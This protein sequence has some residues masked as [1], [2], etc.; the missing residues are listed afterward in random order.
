M[1]GDVSVSLRAK[2]QSLTLGVQTSAEAEYRGLAVADASCE[3]IR[4]K[5]LRIEFFCFQFYSHIL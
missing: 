1:L 2:K 3:K 5:S 4:L